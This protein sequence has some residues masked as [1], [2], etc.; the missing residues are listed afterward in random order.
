MLLYATTVNGAFKKLPVRFG[1]S[2]A[3]KY[4]NF[5]IYRKFQ[6][7]VCVKSEY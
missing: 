2:K 4:R 3:T 1:A 6:D 7:Y 5:V